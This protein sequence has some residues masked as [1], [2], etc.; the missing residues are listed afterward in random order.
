MAGAGPEIAPSL[1]AAPRQTWVAVVGV[2]LTRRS[3][4]SSAGGSQNKRKAAVRKESAETQEYESCQQKIRVGQRRE[5]GKVELCSKCAAIV[6]RQTVGLLGANGFENKR[7]DSQ[8]QKLRTR[9]LMAEASTA[10]QLV[11]SWPEEPPYKEELELLPESDGVRLD[12]TVIPQ[13]MKA[14]RAGDGSELFNSE[15]L[16]AWTRVQTQ[17]FYHEVR[18]EDDERKSIAKQIL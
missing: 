12:G 10:M 15:D 6:V 8:P 16:N 17:E 7:N 18:Q 13:A 14:G 4:T 2:P 3:S 11:R 9:D 1:Q 5:H